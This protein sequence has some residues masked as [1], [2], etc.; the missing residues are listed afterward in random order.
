V[1]EAKDKFSVVGTPEYMSPEV[2]LNEETDKAMDFWAFGKID[3]NKGALI[4]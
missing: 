3:S 1:K 4:H 2:L